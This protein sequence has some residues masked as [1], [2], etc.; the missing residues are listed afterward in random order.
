VRGGGLVV[1]DNGGFDG[2]L[3]PHG[4]QA[5]APL[6]QLESLVDNTPNI[7]LAR[8]EVVDCGG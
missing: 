2:S 3:V 8:V 7:H 5:F 4:L 1:E 6:L